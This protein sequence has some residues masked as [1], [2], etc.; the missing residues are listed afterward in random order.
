MTRRISDSCI[1]GLKILLT[2]FVLVMSLRWEPVSADLSTLSPE[3]QHAIQCIRIVSALEHYHYLGKKLDDS[4]SEQIFDRYIKYL[5][6]SRHL[7]TRNDLEVLERYR[8]RFD[9]DLKRG[10]LKTAY[11]IYN[12]HHGR[13]AQRLTYILGLLKSRESVL[14]LNSSDFLEID[15]A[16]RSWQSSLDDLRRLWEKELI[17]HMITLKLDENGRTDVM[18]TL[19]KIYTTRQTR[20]FQTTPDDVFQ[21]FMNCVTESFDPHTQYFPPRVSE[22]FDIHMRLSLEGIGAVLQ[23][24]YEYTKVVSLVPKGPADKSSLLMPGDRIIG[25]GQGKTGEIK[26]TIGLRI[27]EVV[28]LIRGPKDTYV[29]LKIIP[30]KKSDSTTVVQI[31]RDTVKLEEQSAKKQ[32]KTVVSGTKNYKIGI[33]EIP[34]FYIDFEAY[35][36]GDPE[37]KSTTSDV[38]KLLFELAEENIDGL[39]IDLRDNGGGSLK[40]ASDLTGLFLTS[41]PT[42][43][44]RTKQQISRMYD[45]DPDIHYSG[46]LL[47]LINRMSASA[48][49]IFAGAIK[50][51]QRGIVVGTRSFGKGTVQ[52]LKPLGDGKLKLTSAKFYRVS[53]ESTQN[54]GVIPHVLFPG[55]Y[56]PEETGESSLDGALPWDT[57]PGVPFHAYRSLTP[58]N[59]TL[60]H[61]FQ[62]RRQK[63][64]GM[65]YLEKRLALT[66]Q[67]ETRHLV[68]LNID[69]RQKERYQL[70]QTEIDIENEYLTAQGEPPVQSLEDTTPVLSRYKEILLEQA[71]RI[72]ADMILLTKQQGYAWQ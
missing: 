57:I 13:S 3:R 55:I 16:Q 23:T 17:H 63:D 7:F 68:P 50:D 53:G 44:I 8:Q 58:L 40:E 32:V 27:D 22:D 51:Y 31:M 34:N 14:P 4:L 46:P 19:E 35:H 54:R 21:L 11:A 29:R 10:N 72:M 66:S 70:Q 18:E 71:Q 67:L 52:E 42:V 69:I 56:K 6:P 38:K 24:E 39:I 64:P 12:L 1:L 65:M 62:D 61:Q 45:E 2:G 36:R 37:F 47:V 9:T 30:V 59:D 20:L 33:I 48:S 43:Q 49:E 25:V 60:L 26:D 41:G 28:K 5:D 15:S